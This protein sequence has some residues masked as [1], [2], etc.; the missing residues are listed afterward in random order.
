MGKI[1]VNTKYINDVTQEVRLTK[2]ENFIVGKFE[3]NE[4]EEKIKEFINEFA[5][6][7][8]AK[9]EYNSYFDSHILKV[10][11][12]LNTLWIDE[13]A[14]FISKN[15]EDEHFQSLIWNIVELEEDFPLVISAIAHYFNN[16]YNQDELI[17]LLLKL[18][19][20]LPKLPKKSTKK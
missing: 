17:E 6:L 15:G 1:F 3:Y 14:I 9:Y 13:N 2:G 11:N 10:S 5:K 18:V 8:G 20:S 19:W 7:I 16:P 12:E 4:T